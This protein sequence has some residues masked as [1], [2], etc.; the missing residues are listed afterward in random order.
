MRERNWFR[1]ATRVFLPVCLVVVTA[2]EMQSQAP[3][4]GL[5]IQ[6]GTLIDVQRGTLVPN[7][8]IVVEGDRITQVG[9][10]G[11][12]AAPTG[13]QVIDAQGRFVMPGLWDSH[14]HTRDYDAPLNITHGVTSTMDMGNIMDWVMT[15]GEGR[16]KGLLFGPRIFAQG[17]SLGG[18][19]GSHQWNVKAPDEYRWAA[20][21]NIEYGA[22]FLKI[23]QAAT[24]E[25]IRAAAE[26]ARGAGL[27]VAAHVGRSDAREAIEAGVTNLLHGAGLAAAMAKTPADREMILKNP[28][29]LRRLG[30]VGNMINYL[31]DPA[32]FDDM[33]K[34]MIERNVRLEPTMANMYKGVHQFSAKYMQENMMLA[35]RNDLRL[36]PWYIRNW[37][38]EGTYPLP[39]SD[40]TRAKMQKGWEYAQLFTRKFAAA[41]GKLMVGT[42]AYIYMPSGLALWQE[43][44]L[45]ATAGAPPLAILQGATV[46]PAEYVHQEKN[47]G[48]IEAGKLADIIILARNP[49]QDVTNIRSLETVIQHGKVQ[50]RGY[51]DHTYARANAI[52]A[53]YFSTLGRPAPRP[54]ITSVAP[55]AVPMGSGPVTLT[56]KGRNFARMHR[57]LWDDVDL[58]VKKFSR[59]EM[60]V[61]VPAELVRNVGTYK[62]HM[63]T[64]GPEAREGAEFETEESINYQ[65]VLV[66][67]GKKLNER[68][69]GQTLSNEF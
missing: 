68:W 4:N 31:M 57:V 50:K 21:K 39:A 40:D 27:N 65:N 67:F 51:G 55:I 1:L 9:T 41:G 19:I 69:N 52:P 36:P 25:M 47:L 58:E 44:E 64:G 3:S 38:I 8:M 11:Q 46:N 16:N 42:D 35:L 43:M 66:T 6:G 62:V 60:E 45:L 56:I 30:H 49:L 32:K 63:I 54:Y 14:A 53:P 48:M 17:M 33:V 13:A 37:A 2:G 34:F 28:E 15:V 61:V 22:S 59:E 23:Y 18:E 12:T 26:V 7:S 29:E 5:V 20:R 10:V 24:P